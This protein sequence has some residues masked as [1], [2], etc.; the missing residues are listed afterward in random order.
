LP[1]A[2]FLRHQL[3]EFLEEMF[4]RFELAEPKHKGNSV[5][6]DSIDWNSFD[7]KAIEL[8]AINE[9]GQFFGLTER[10]ANH[11]FDLL[12]PHLTDPHEPRR[13]V[14]VSNMFF[15]LWWKAQQTQ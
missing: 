3:D 7:W 8:H 14:H 6:D 1:R 13:A 12:A 11:L 5:M 9:L 15:L 4:H 2:V 10:E